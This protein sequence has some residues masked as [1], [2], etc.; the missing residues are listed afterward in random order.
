MGPV[1]M[2]TILS[3]P[4]TIADLPHLFTSPP[5]S[6]IPPHYSVGDRIIPTDIKGHG[7]L[8]GP[9]GHEILTIYLI[10]WRQDHSCYY[11][12]AKA[13]HGQDRNMLLLQRNMIVKPKFEIGDRVRLRADADDEA[14]RARDRARMYQ[15]DLTEEEQGKQPERDAGMSE[16]A[17]AGERK[18][19]LI[20]PSGHEEQWDAEDS[21]TWPELPELN[22]NGDITNL[23]RHRVYKDHKVLS[24]RYSQT[25][26]GS[27]NQIYLQKPIVDLEGVQTSNNLF[28]ASGRFEVAVDRTS[29][30]DSDTTATTDST[31]TDTE[32][33]S[34]DATISASDD[35]GCPTSPTIS[36]IIRIYK[37]AFSVDRLQAVGLSG[38]WEGTITSIDVFGG[39]I[40]YMLDL[41]S[42]GEAVKGEVDGWTD[43]RMDDVVPYI[44]EKDLVLVDAYGD[45]SSVDGEGK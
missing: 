42:H 34:T 7:L 18:I 40:T 1:A 27:E 3:S 35:I 29:A 20:K 4:L 36:T 32:S 12:C 38:H 31:I 43:E 15:Y 10:G 6:G 24:Q 26:E 2:S 39:M 8:L 41:S 5:R 22:G 9:N 28:L 45:V 14:D 21:K 23:Q 30:G 17:R 37:V 33:V 11:Y 19:S 16:T 25:T 44:K 13:A